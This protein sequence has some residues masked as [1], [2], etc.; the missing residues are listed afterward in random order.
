[1]SDRRSWMILGCAAV[2]AL[3]GCRSDGPSGPPPPVPGT[4]TVT[5]TTPEVDDRAILI[6]VDGPEAV[7]SVAAAGTG[8]YTVHAR[9]SGT[10]FRAAVFGKLANGPLVSFSVPDVNKLA[11]YTATVQDVV[12]PDNTLRA[13]SAGYTLKVTK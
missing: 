3:A 12:A 5:L 2:V 8:G 11:S 10:S 9:T 1:M 4:L 6:S 13:S 7:G